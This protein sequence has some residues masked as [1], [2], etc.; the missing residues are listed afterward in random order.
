[1]LSRCRSKE[2]LVVESV[3]KRGVASPCDRPNLASQISA[4]K[5][6]MSELCTCRIML[7]FGSN[8]GPAGPVLGRSSMSS[9]R[10]TVKRLHLAHSCYILNSVV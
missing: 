5:N 9:L 2:T 4:F 3:A 7:Y 6:K 8:G 1:M 10:P